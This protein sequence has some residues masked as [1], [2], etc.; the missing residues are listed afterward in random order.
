M[1]KKISSSQREKD[2]AQPRKGAETPAGLR[3]KAKELRAWA[4][5]YEALAKTF[6]ENRVE[7]ASVDGVQKYSR[8]MSLLKDYLAAVEYWMKRAKP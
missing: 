4:G 1:A 2:E 3:E 8:S 7:A 5:R 6:E